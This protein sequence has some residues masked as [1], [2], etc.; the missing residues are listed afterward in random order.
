[1]L[2]ENR[3][4]ATFVRR[5]EQLARALA[6]TPALFASGKPR[7][8]NYAANQFPFRANSHFLYFFGLPFPDGVGFFDGDSWTLYLPEPGPDDALWEGEV[9]G[10]AALSELTG[11]PV[12]SRE[13]LPQALARGPVA[14]LPTPELE[15]CLELSSLLGREVRPGRLEGSDARLADAVISLRLRHDAAAIRE[16]RAAADITAAAHRA[17]MRATRPGLREAE[18][19]AAMEAAILAHDVVPAYNP[20]VTIHGEVL[21]NHHYHHTLEAGDLLLADVGG[22]S[23]GGFAG[24][25]TRTWPVT[26]RYSTTQ[27]EMYEV[28]LR[29]QRET[30]AAVRPGVRYRDV[31]LVAHHALARGLVE[32]G[33]LRG[34]PEELVAEG[35]SALLFPHGVGHLLGLDVHDM[36]DLG[37][38]AGYAPGRT[39]SPEFGH[40]FLRLD[41]DLEPGMAVTIEP[42]LYVVPAIL[43]NPKLTAHAG[44]RLDLRLLARFS[45]VRG[46][47]IEDDVLVTDSGQEVLTAA[48]P[49]DVADVEA[50][51]AGSR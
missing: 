16:L 27:R 7:A 50:V 20:I 41:R 39:R 6:G 10:F 34:H 15:T 43:R 30:I 21:H 29:A 22:E 14:T 38:R 11:C 47:R 1:M 35:V 28:V 25:V 49:K 45:D 17:G 33:I 24:D 19:R 13:Q 32:L 5:R 9:P 42:G 12:K 8:R 46:I 3:D 18:V 23:A 48:I 2:P 26:G 44:D 36:E 51:M 4:P 31:H 37:D 40:R